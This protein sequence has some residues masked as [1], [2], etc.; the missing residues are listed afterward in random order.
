MQRLQENILTHPALAWHHQ[1]RQQLAQLNETNLA[2]LYRIAEQA[3]EF[4]ITLDVTKIDEFSVDIATQGIDETWLKTI[5]AKAGFRGGYRG[6]AERPFLEF[7]ATPRRPGYYDENWTQAR[8]PEGFFRR[9]GFTLNVP[10]IDFQLPQ[11][12]P[13]WED[14]TRLMPW[15]GLA[16]MWAPPAAGKLFWWQRALIVIFGTTSV[17]L[18]LS[19]LGKGMITTTIKEV[20]PGLGVMEEIVKNSEENNK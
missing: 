2:A 11:W 18:L 12:V 16:A 6:P 5:A 14:V 10:G 20:V 19:M 13:E 1:A 9:G 3:E 17:L 15:Y 7:S 4:D 8:D